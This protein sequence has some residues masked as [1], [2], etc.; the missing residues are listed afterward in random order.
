MGSSEAILLAG[1]AMKKRWQARRKA[2]GKDTSK[3]NL[4]MGY[5]PALCMTS[6]PQQPWDSGCCGSTPARLRTRKP[7]SQK[8]LLEGPKHLF[9]LESACE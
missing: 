4:V 2:E 9:D 1:L 3:P 8:W 5:A 6:K 7:R